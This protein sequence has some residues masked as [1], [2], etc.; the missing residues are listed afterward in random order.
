MKCVH[1]SCKCGGADHDYLAERY[2]WQWDLMDPGGWK[3]NQN[4][5]V[6]DVTTGICY[7]GMVRGGRGYIEAE[8][9]ELIESGE[10]E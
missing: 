6:L 3:A 4:I 9:H 7:T 10:L 5:I 1:P 2:R 8:I